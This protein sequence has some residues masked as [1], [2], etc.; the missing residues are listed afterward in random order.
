[1]DSGWIVFVGTARLE[2]AVMLA[3]GRWR[4]TKGMA[5]GSAAP[6]R[7]PALYHTVPHPQRISVV[8]LMGFPFRS[9]RFF[10]VPFGFRRNPSGLQTL[11]MEQKTTVTT[12]IRFAASAE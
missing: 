9:V 11:Q 3:V 8:G 10:S 7:I 12:V 5:T 4:S 6:H 2:L 1:M